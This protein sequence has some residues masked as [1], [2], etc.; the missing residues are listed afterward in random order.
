M[1]AA[2]YLEH[3]DRI[4]L[5]WHSF[6]LN[7]LI[8]SSHIF[9]HLRIV[10][11][12][13]FYDSPHTS[14]VLLRGSHFTSKPLLTCLL[15]RVSS[16]HSALLP[17]L[18]G[19]RVSHSRPRISVSPAA[20]LGISTRLHLRAVDNITPLSNKCALILWCAFLY[21]KRYLNIMLYFS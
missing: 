8:Y 10:S 14:H 5:A 7:P 3:V 2:V 21:W 16:V 17:F 11:F 15:S 1:T 12:F 6:G 19:R 20:A 9:S 4:C 18:T 13:L